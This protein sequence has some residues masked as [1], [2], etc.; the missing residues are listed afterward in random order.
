MPTIAP[1]G[2]WSSPIR[3]ESLTEAQVGLGGASV[4]SVSN[5]DGVS[6]VD[7]GPG[8]DSVSGADGV[9]VYWLESRPEEAGRSVVVRAGADGAAIDDL[10]PAPFNVRTRVHEYGGGAFAAKND[11]RLAVNFSDQRLYR[12]KPGA[13]PVA[14]TP[15]SEKKLRY[16]DMAIQPERGLVY[17]V[18]EDHR[19]DGEAVNTIVRLD[20]NAG[21]SEGTIVASGHD[22]FAAPRLSPD[23]KQLAFIS[24]DHPNMPWDATT[25]WLADI[26]DDGT[27]A[28]V[29]PVAGGDG[30]S[31]MQPSFS[32]G[33]SLYFVSD[34]T[35]WWNLFRLDEG[36]CRPVCAMDAEFAVPAWAFGQS[37]YGFLSEDRTLAGYTQNGRWRLA[38]ID[39]ANG[40]RTPID[41]PYTSISSLSVHAGRAVL[42]VGAADRPAAIIELEPASGRH[43]VL[44]TAGALTISPDLISVP[45][46]I[47]F[48]TEGGAVAYGFYYPPKNPDYKS[49]PGQRPPLIVKSHGGP[50]GNTSDQLNLGTQFWTSRGFALVDVDYGGS[51]GYGRAYRERLNGRWGEVDVQDCI[52]AARHLVDAGKADPDRLAITGGSAG[53][54]T[55]LAALTFHDLFKA[56]A[57]HYGVSDLEAL[58]KET[59]KFESRYL[60]NLIGP[61]PDGVDIYRA[62]SPIHHVGGLTSPMIF[63]QGLEDV[64]VP[65]NQA[66][67]MVDALRKKGIPVAYL[68]FEGEQHGFRK[69]ETIH[70]V[71]RAELA[72][73][74]Q[75]FGF[76]PA[77]GFSD[78]VIEN[79]D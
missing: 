62:S 77:D 18:R 57:S 61:Y 3:P 33:G 14:L 1:F 58:A 2:T 60:D 76:E 23:G 71:C 50:T 44:K 53:G 68:A 12:L 17:L 45:E 41:L 26:R 11:I 16:A 7:P 70:A 67:M 34:Q 28:D 20:L 51:T 47:A 73:Y 72:F 66:E 4:D 59:H 27:L 24:W 6:S 79:L 69:A 74:G 35:G 21:E 55:T 54:F 36:G 49:P 56:G 25:L 75:V 31:I 15:A 42:R 64:I 10:T 37:T 65:P 78:L 43:R 39:R 5:V 29:R 48:P 46:T 40:Q 9:T 30:V 38:I 13:M 52:N 63:F 8:A 19:G 32:P 22:F